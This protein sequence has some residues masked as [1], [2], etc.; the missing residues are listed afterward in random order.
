MAARVRF[1]PVLSL[2]LLFATIA[3]A[4]AAHAAPAYFD[5]PFYGADID[6]RPVMAAVADLNRDGIP[7]LAIPNS[8]HAVSILLGRGDGFF[9]PHREVA[10]ATGANATVGVA[11]ADLNGDGI[12][13]L[14]AST[15]TNNTVTLLWGNG[16]GTFR[17]G[18]QF[19]TAEYPTRPAAADLNGDG[20]ADL[21]FP[22]WYGQVVWLLLSAGA[23]TFVPAGTVAAPGGC[24]AVGAGD[25]D[26]DGN[27]DLAFS[28]GNS[29]RVAAGDGTGSFAPP[30]ILEETGTYVYRVQVTDLDGDGRADLGHATT[31]GI[32][33]RLADGAGGF[34]IRGPLN[35]GVFSGDFASGDLDADGLPEL[36]T[37]NGS[38]AS[39][40]PGLA[41]GNWGAPQHLATGRDNRALALADLDRDGKLDALLCSYDGA[42]ASVL[43]GNGRGR[44]GGGKFVPTGFT[45][46]RLAFADFDFDG[47]ADLVAPDAAANRVVL[48]HGDGR[49][50]FAATASLDVPQPLANA[51]AADVNG[52]FLVDILALGATDYY[53]P[54][55]ATLYLFLADAPGSFQPPQEIPCGV[56]LA[57]VH[58]VDLNLDGWRDLVVL[59]TGTN[60]QWGSDPGSVDI[61]FGTGGGEF[62]PPLRPNV[63]PLPSSVAI[64]DA[65]GDRKPDLVVGSLGSS[66]VRLLRTP[67]TQPTSIPT[68]GAVRSVVL[69]E[70]T[71]DTWLDVGA[72]VG[73]TP[74]IFRSLGFGNF[75]TPGTALASTGWE[76]RLLER[77]L[78]GDGRAELLATRRSNTLSIYTGVGN[79][80]L[81]SQM[82]VG[83]A[84]GGGI[85]VIVEVT[86]DGR[87]DILVPVSAFP[88]GALASGVLVLANQ[89]A[90]IVPT[91][92]ADIE[93]EADASGVRLRWSAVTETPGSFQ[94]FRSTAGSDVYSHLAPVVPASPGRHRYEF[95]DRT[96][97]P[98]SSYAYKIGW[99]EA[100]GMVYSSAMVVRTQ[101]A[102]LALD[103]PRYDSPRRRIVFAYST[104]GAGDTRLALFDVAGRRVR[105]LAAGGASPTRGQEAWDG[106]G[107]SGTAVAAGVYWVRLDWNGRSQSRRFLWVR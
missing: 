62:G 33:L 84:V 64:G 67:F 38:S 76:E 17:T 83:S 105:V 86:G 99:P 66:G 87:P 90:P 68:S 1:D 18:P 47:I 56:G 22:C 102:A 4:A 96:A 89:S 6:G 53:N 60:S 80:G 61:R 70:L 85:P 32:T 34:H 95:E 93:I 37:A 15:P 8:G 9:E 11:A 7:D 52:D 74:T 46:A 51:A 20:V 91:L 88:G 97:L 2:S 69:T 29:L 28:A 50:G 78:D 63:G 14:A 104:P 40:L 55:P 103:P 44:L 41:G 58:V 5:T 25:L 26:G 36:V 75:A 94:V 24:S 12:V 35:A 23:G 13:D 45:P 59:N 100:D 54:V 31:T 101:L 57:E 77:D 65:D 19:A 21:A 79:S 81:F 27:A 49:G 107:E 39:I 106:T 16:D 3:A 42:T 73:S 72:L 98:G 43:L 71:G 30:V 10:V 48:M 82:I 92:F